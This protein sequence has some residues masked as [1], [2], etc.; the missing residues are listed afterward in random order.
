MVVDGRQDHLRD[1]VEDDTYAIGL[2]QCGPGYSAVDEDGRVLCVAGVYSP[3]EGRAAAHAILASDCGP[4]LLSIVRAIGAYL[5]TAPF[6]RIEA[7][8]ET[9]RPECHHFARLLG[10]NREGTMARF[11]AGLDYDLYARISDARIGRPTNPDARVTE[12]AMPWS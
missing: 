11:Q 5:K 1:L 9:S 12:G 7:Y 10:F 3:W 4:R 8:V 6:E 2:A